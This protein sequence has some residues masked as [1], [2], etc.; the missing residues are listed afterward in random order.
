MRGVCVGNQ[1]VAGMRGC[2]ALKLEKPGGFH[3]KLVSGFH[4]LLIH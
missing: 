2:L 1:G 4:T 3:D